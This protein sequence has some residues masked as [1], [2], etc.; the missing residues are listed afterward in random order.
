VFARSPTATPPSWDR[1]GTRRA[2]AVLVLLLVLV[3]ALAGALSDTRG[4]TSTL[5]GGAASV[6]LS[7]ALTLLAIFAVTFA[8]L[9]LY[10]ILT[11]PRGSTASTG[12]RRRPFWR[13]V[14]I[15]LVLP[16]IF[17]V[18]AIL[19]RHR[20]ASHLLLPVEASNPSPHPAGHPAVHFVPSASAATLG[21][22]LLVVG[23]LVLAGWMRARRRGPV[24]GLHD[25]LAARSDTSLPTGTGATMAESLASI[26][27]PD[28]HEEADPRKAVIACYLAMT[29]AAAAAGVERHRSE[30]PSEFLSRL[31]CSLGSSQD[32]ARRL[33]RLFEAARYTR[34]PVDEALRADA[35]NALTQVQE[36]LARAGRLVAAST[37]GAGA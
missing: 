22:V 21:V 36:E 35:I 14:A 18:V 4:G 37:G 33:T 26:R 13:G 8:A 32:S 9:V 6:A 11:S 28:P 12:G 15:V 16:I 7:V 17:A 5:R 10:G 23:V 25:L 27:V 34:R 24:S 1:V 31:L 3:G 20:H 30:T 29:A 2:G 19:H